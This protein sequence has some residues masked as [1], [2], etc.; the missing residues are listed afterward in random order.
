MIPATEYRE[1]GDFVV[2]QHRPDWQGPHPVLLLVHGWTGDETVMW[3][4]SQRLPKDRLILAP[5]GFYPA[6][7]GGYS[8]Q[9]VR[10][11]GWPGYQD[12]LPAADRLLNQLSPANFPSADFSRMA[13]IG[14]S[15]GAA[16]L[17]TAAILHPEKFQV[18]CGL[19]GFIPSGMES[20]ISAK[21]LVGKPIFAAHGR[22]DEIVPVD[23][24]R[25]AVAYLEQAGA[26]VAYCEEDVGHKLSAPCFRS[27][28][29]F[30]NLHSP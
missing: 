12:L 15:Q 9:P 22:L 5:R 11:Q 16:L 26:K 18:V 7:T 19:S 28:E 6:P 3:I 21:P 29:N 4:F 13:A 10:R 25:E 8:W 30:L 2:R 20:M 17:Y 27:M 24:A 1:I 23:K 14:F